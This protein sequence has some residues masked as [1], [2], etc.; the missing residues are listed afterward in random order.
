LALQATLIPGATKDKALQQ[1]KKDWDRGLATLSWIHLHTEYSLLHLSAT[2]FDHHPILLNSNQSAISPRPFRFE[3]FWT[4]DPTC[5]AVI[6][7][8]WNQPVQGPPAQCLIRKHFHTKVSLTRWNSTH[9]GR[10]QKKIK[11][12]KAWIDQVQ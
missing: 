7:A 10:I 8:A 4:R 11:S 6:Q 5:E 1:S 3:A 2:N 12:T 9:F